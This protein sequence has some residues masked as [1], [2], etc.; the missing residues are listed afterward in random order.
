MTG[1]DSG[2]YTWA[3]GDGA[4][5]LEGTGFRVDVE[6][7]ERGVRADVLPRVPRGAPRAWGG[8]VEDVLAGL[9]DRGGGF[10]KGGWCKTRVYVVFGG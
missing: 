2:T 1:R 7:V 6:R 9:G 4:T 10:E 5:V 8:R 3:T